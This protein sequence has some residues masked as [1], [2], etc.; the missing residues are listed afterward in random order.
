MLLFAWLCMVSKNERVMVYEDRI[1][2]ISPWGRIT[3][4]QNEDILKL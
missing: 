1:E 2:H 3:R 4:I